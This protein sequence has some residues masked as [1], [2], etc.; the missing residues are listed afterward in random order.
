MYIVKNIT[1]VPI[2]IGK[3]DIMKPQETRG[4]KGGKELEKYKGIPN[5][6]ITKSKK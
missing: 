2:R 1:G 6:K 3:K 4:V 5:L